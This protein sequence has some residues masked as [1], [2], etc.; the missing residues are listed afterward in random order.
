[1]TRP[2]YF[3]VKLVRLI[4]MQ[5]RAISDGVTVTADAADFVHSFA[6][7]HIEMG[8]WAN[9]GALALLVT[10]TVAVLKTGPPWARWALLLVWGLYVQQW[11]IQFNVM[12]LLVAAKVIQLPS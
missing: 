1:M 4:H 3:T 7:M 9:W 12:A 11:S 5:G 2:C 6:K 8:D 10:G